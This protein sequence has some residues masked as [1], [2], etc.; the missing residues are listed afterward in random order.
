M[1]DRPRQAVLSSSSPF[2]GLRVISVPSAYKNNPPKR[3]YNTPNCSGRTHP[4]AE[5][6]P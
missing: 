6:T 2:S 3:R 1:L 5:K 4:D